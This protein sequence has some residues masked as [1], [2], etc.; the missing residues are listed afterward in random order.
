AP[1]L[2]YLALVETGVAG[3]VAP[4]ELTAAVPGRGPPRRALVRRDQRPGDR[5]LAV[6]VGRAA[7]VDRRQV[8]AGQFVHVVLFDVRQ[9]LEP[10]A[11]AVRVGGVAAG[12]AAL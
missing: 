3:V 7:A 6:V 9:D 12:G 5:V 2:V 1:V 4:P 11:P 10:V 8:E